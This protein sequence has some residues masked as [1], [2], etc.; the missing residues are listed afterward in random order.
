V[1][2]DRNQKSV[3]ISQ[4]LFFNETGWDKEDLDGK[5]VLEV[6]CGAGKFSQVVLE[7]TIANLYS[8]DLSQAVEANYR[9]NHHYGNRLKIF[10]ASIYEMPFADQSFDK[11]FCLDVLQYTP[12]FRKSIFSLASKLRRSG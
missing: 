9:N 3:Q 2:I 6:G 5:D 7:H 1:Q 11:V 4:K 12:D 10:Q 8:V